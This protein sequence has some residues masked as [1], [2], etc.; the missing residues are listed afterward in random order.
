MKTDHESK[1]FVFL[2]IPGF[3]LV[4]LSCAVDALRAANV[5]A[6]ETLFRW[7]MVANSAGEVTSSSGLSISCNGIGEDDSIDVLAVCGGERSHL[8]ASSTVDSWLKI[9]GRRQMMVGSI[10]DGAYVVADAGL[11]NTVRSTIHWKCQ[12]PYRERFPNLDVRTSIMEIDRNRFSCAGG[13][14]SLDLMLY[15]I[16]REKDNEFV[17]RIADNYFHDVVRNDEQLQPMASRYR[18]AARNH[19]ISDALLIMDSELETPSPISSIAE[20]LNVSHRQLNRLFK[21]Y[22]ETSPGQYYREI[23]LARAARL[24]RQT[25]LSS[26]EIALGCGFQSSSHLSKYF[27][28]RFG[29]TPH[30]YR[31]NG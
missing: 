3:S 11:F 19:I 24:L 23:R 22:L 16:A 7:T 13:T 30:Q 17:G 6:G 2:L 20:R 27:K 8:F 31:I 12:S 25:E 10:S 9:C 29:V 18:F 28:T 15:F 1:H 21:R 4:A 14:A 5:E 26:G